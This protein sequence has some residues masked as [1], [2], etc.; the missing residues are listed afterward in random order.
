MDNDEEVKEPPAGERL[1]DGRPTISKAEVLVTDV[2]MSHEIAFGGRIWIQCDNSKR[3]AAVRDFCPIQAN[4]ESTEIDL[5]Q[6]DRFGGD[7][8]LVCRYVAAHGAKFSFQT[9]EITNEIRPGRDVYCAAWRPSL[10]KPII[11][12]SVNASN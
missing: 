1:V 9:G 7:K 2:G 3:Q 8:Q 12:L 6:N 10:L 11:E 4:L 5:F